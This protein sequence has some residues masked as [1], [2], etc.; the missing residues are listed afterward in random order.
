MKKIILFRGINCEDANVKE[1]I[2]LNGILGTEGKSW[3]IYF[4]N[5]K[6]PLVDINIHDYSDS[7]ELFPESSSRAIC[8]CG[9]ELSASYYACIHNEGNFPLVVKFQTEIDD[10]YIDGRDFLYTVFQLWDMKSPNNFS[11]I[12]Q[13][14]RGLFGDSILQY[15]DQCLTE[16][17][18][19]KRIIYCNYACHD[20]DVKFAHLNNQTII[21]GRYKTLFKSAFIVKAPIC[22][23]NILDVF[24][25]G[26]PSITPGITLENVI[27]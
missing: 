9:D 12:R 27:R 11:K 4:R 18:H 23:G 15:F 2:L 3:E 13:Q 10:I 19:A 14:I 8:A 16:K 1:L 25:P 7:N 24:T 26:H 21:K 22:K 20:N 5:K 17:D 6:R